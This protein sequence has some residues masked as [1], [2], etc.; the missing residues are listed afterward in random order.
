MRERA[1]ELGDEDAMA[2]VW[3]VRLAS[4]DDRVRVR[5]AQGEARLLCCAAAERSELGERED[6][7]WLLS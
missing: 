2:V 4:L 1:S 3:R 5:G 7:A 6:V